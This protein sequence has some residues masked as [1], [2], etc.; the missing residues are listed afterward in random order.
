MYEQSDRNDRCNVY[1]LN[2]FI[3]LWDGCNKWIG[4][5]QI[6]KIEFKIYRITWSNY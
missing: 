4:V 5:Q 3:S 1:C 2:K 6:F